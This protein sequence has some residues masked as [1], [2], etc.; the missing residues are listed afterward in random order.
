MG[1]EDEGGRS[2]DIPV[3]GMLAAIGGVEVDHSLAG[4]LSSSKTTLRERYILLDI[5]SRQ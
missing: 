4:K 3:S 1:C 2:S 5:R